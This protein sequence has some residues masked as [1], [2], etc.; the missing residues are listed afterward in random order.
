MSQHP[1]LR[2]AFALAPLRP[3]AWLQDILDV[4]N[5]IL[6]RWIQAEEL[7]PEG[8]VRAMIRLLKE[9]QGECQKAIAGLE[10]MLKLGTLR[11]VDRDHPR[12]GPGHNPRDFDE[13]L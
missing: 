6:R 5:R 10:E 12:L 3:A 13:G 2:A 4:D 11:H 8:V 7:P 9:R 1:F